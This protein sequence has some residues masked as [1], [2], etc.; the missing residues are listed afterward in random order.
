MKGDASMEKVHDD[1]FVVFLRYDP[2]T[3]P[4][5]GDA[6]EQPLASCS[7]YGE[8]RR[9]RQVLQATAPGE[10]VIRY[11]GPAGGGD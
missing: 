4:A 2:N 3:E 1:Q 7:T 11:T 10:C 6:S 9:I 5:S 8:A